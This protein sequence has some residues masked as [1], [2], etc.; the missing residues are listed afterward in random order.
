MIELSGDSERLLEVFCFQGYK[1][2]KVAVIIS[3]KGTFA[4]SANVLLEI[5]VYIT[6]FPVGQESQ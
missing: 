3:S 6:G 1:K 2:G 4:I 5:S